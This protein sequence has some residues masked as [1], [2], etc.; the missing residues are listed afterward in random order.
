MANKK[1][2]KNTFTNHREHKNTCIPPVLH[3]LLP[4]KNIR[5]S[6]FSQFLKTHN[7]MRT[8]SF[9]RLFTATVF[10]TGADAADRP[11]RNRPGSNA[12]LP[13]LSLHPPLLEL[14]LPFDA[15]LELLVLCLQAAQV[16]SLLKCCHQLQ[17]GERKGGRQGGGG[18]DGVV[19]M[20]GEGRGEGGSDGEK[21][22]RG[23]TTETK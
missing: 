16:R 20:W 21:E 15:V 14:L 2:K 12:A 23:R 11:P 4:F 17:K 8:S 10:L 3:Q 22:G 7:N 6:L 18:G 9:P 13:L 5:T 1:I 19:E